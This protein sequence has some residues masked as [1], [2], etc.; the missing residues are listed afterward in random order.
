MDPNNET[1][2]DRLAKAIEHSYRE[3]EPFRQLNK[4]LVEE[5]A[6]SGYG[7]S[8]TPKFETVINLMN[9][10]VTAYT[11]ALAANRPR[12][13]VTCPDPSRN[14]FCKKY[15]VAMNNLIKEI[16]L[17]ITLRQWVLDAFFCVGIVKVHMA[18]SGLVELENDLWMDPG[19]P[20]ASNVSLDNWVHDMGAT[21]WSQT[22]FSG[23]TYRIPMEDLQHPMYE[24]DLVKDLQESRRTAIEEN[25]L[26]FLSHYDTADGTDLEPMVDL[27][28][29]WIPRDGKIYT[30][31]LSQRSQFKITGKPLAVMDWTG[32]EMGPYKKMGFNDVPE[33]IMPTSPASHLATLA[34]IAN[35][36][37]RKQKRQASRQKDVHMYTAAG[38]D[39]AARLQ[40]SDDGQWIN[41][42]DPSQVATLKMGGVDQ[43]N[44]AFL[45]SVM[46]LFDRMAGN[47]TGM[48][49]LG[50]QAPTAS[51]EQ[52]LQGRI[53]SKEAQMQYTVL[54]ATTSL[55]RDLGWL[56]WNDQVRVMPGSFPIQGTDN[57]TADATWTP[58]HR[59]G[60]YGDYN[61]DIDVYSMSYESPEQKAAKLNMLLTQIY[62]PM[63][64]ILMSQGGVLNL[65]KL[66]EQHAQLLNLPQLKECISFGNIPSEGTGETTSSPVSTRT[67]ER[68]SV[69][70]G[71]TPQNRANQEQQAWLAAAS[72][73]GGQ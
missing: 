52:I 25:R 62:G 51:Q 17:E 47:L 54:D 32:P 56:L 16:G 43:G 5:Y 60:E 70:T 2:R 59:E 4:S 49:G 3:L 44:Q 8:G 19:R 50:A 38:K 29:I 11:M 73:N 40:R 36:L 26:E 27:A 42:N 30:Y 53:S 48:L 45:I 46:Q 1:H 66:V 71:G 15:E 14:Y 6:G 41:V 7:R 23:D 13:L 58:D 55:I 37:M 67:Y 10:A 9:Q 21:K 72:Q 24:Q 28:D 63:A 34:R 65:Q 12:V 57:Y 35:N 20:F 31:A 22:K 39:D 33:N 69:P 61:I 18:D 64:Q 68:R